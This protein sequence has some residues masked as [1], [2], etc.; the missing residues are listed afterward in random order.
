M[1]IKYKINCNKLYRN[2]L[3]FCNN[4]SKKELNK[5]MKYILKTIFIVYQF[6]LNSKHVLSQKFCKVVFKTHIHKNL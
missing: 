4:Q 3:Q 2:D 5:Q 6:C 1:R